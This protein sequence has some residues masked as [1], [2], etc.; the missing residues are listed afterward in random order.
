MLRNF[1]GREVNTAGDGDP[2]GRALARPRGTVILNYSV[3]PIGG[4]MF[5]IWSASHRAGR[6][7]LNHRDWMASSPITMTNTKIFDLLRDDQK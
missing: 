5:A 4:A 6:K 3:P 7:D 1:N 2:G